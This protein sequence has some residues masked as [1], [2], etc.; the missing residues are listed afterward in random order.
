M[1][2]YHVQTDLDFKMKNK[3]INL[4][5]IRKFSLNNCIQV[6]SFGRSRTIANYCISYS[7]ND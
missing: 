7:N 3:K 6:D 1:T 2:T 4:G 5:E